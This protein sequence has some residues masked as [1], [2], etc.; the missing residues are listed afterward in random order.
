MSLSLMIARFI[1][2]E[3]NPRLFSMQRYEY[4]I[5]SFR[6]GLTAKHRIPAWKLIQDNDLGIT[7]ASP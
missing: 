4:R 2:V 1:A 5:S 6:S 3:S 7:T